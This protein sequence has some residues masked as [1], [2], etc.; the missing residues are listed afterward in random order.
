VT[1]PGGMN[2]PCDKKDHDLFHAST[3]TTVG[4][5]NKALFW[6]SSWI[7]GRAASH[8]APSLLKKATRTS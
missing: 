5:D 7:G 4:N 3:V 8:I 6:K 1:W 2:I